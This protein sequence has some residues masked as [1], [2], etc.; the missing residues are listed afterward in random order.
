MNLRGGE[1]R[2][3]LALNA[4]LRLWTSDAL[5]FFVCGRSDSGANGHVLSLLREERGGGLLLSLDSLSLSLT[6]TA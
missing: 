4:D 1:R 2:S 3:D 6:C 5:L